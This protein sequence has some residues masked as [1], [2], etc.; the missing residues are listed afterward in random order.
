M[1]WL[2]SKTKATII[3]IKQ[4]INL[5]FILRVKQKLYMNSTKD[6]GHITVASAYLR[7]SVK[8]VT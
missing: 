4:G 6:E 8:H 1:I 7:P 2:K 3:V 5:N